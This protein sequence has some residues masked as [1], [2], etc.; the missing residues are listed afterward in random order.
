MSGS[1]RSVPVVFREYMYAPD[2]CAD[3]LMSILKKPVNQKVVEPAREPNDRDGAEI[4]EDS[5][6]ARIM[7]G[8]P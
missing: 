2:Y 5:A 3:A 7:P 1:R 4:K 6:Y 8:D